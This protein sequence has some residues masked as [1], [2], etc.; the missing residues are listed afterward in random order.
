MGNESEKP[1]RDLIG[2]YSSRR[3]EVTDEGRL[4]FANAALVF[5]D[6]EDA[7]IHTTAAE[8]GRIMKATRNRIAGNGLYLRTGQEFRDRLSIDPAWKDK[9]PNEWLSILSG[10]A[11]LDNF[12]LIAPGIKSAVNA[13]KGLDDPV[14]QRH[15]KRMIRQTTLPSR[16]R[17]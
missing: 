1:S 3:F 2:E 7:G 6:M 9:S 14:L 15:L 12:E 10:A 13:S 5:E 11:V 8:R 4:R 17:D 16:A